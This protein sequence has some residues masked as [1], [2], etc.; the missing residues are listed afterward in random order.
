MSLSAQK[1][2][3]HFEFST[4]VNERFELYRQQVA[5]VK[6]SF[7]E[8][9]EQGLSANPKILSPKYFYDDT[10]SELFEKITTTPEYYPT[11][12]ERKILA[13]NM[14]DII[15][16]CPD[17]EI[18]AE[19]GSGSSEKTKIIIQSF[20]RGND[21]LTYMPIDVSDILIPSSENLLRTHKNLRVTGIV[22]EYE[23]G[24]ELLSDISDAPKLILFLGSSIG[25]FDTNAAKELLRHIS[26]SMNR[27]DSLLIG[28]DLL[29]NVDVLH[30]AYND[31]Q[32]YTKAFNLNMLHRINRELDAN[33][34]TEQYRHKAFF[35][36][37]ASRVEMH[38]IS[39]QEQLV[40]VNKLNRKFSFKKG[41]SIH[42]ENSHKFNDA[43]INDLAASAGLRVLRSWKDA[44]NYFALTL[45]NLI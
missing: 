17:T 21:H 4:L 40:S 10:G 18:I 2:V 32:G 5:D 31:T 16:N 38:L 39:E 28:F 15:E 27:Q 45:F 23:P 34:A 42:T 36:S 26:D 6:N 30:A 43:S 19:L 22:S 44:D 11:R 13:K 7:A 3:N 12:T 9:V 25:N 41:E 35:N 29:K 37:L 20:L 1:S 33:F 8:D 14:S 24:L